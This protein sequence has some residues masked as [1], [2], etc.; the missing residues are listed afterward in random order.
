MIFYLTFQSFVLLL[1]NQF[2]N[3]PVNQFKYVN[4]ND[5]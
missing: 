1:V 3:E 5:R 2:T 4:N